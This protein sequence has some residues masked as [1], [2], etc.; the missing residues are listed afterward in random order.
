MIDSDA[1]NI[2]LEFGLFSQRIQAFVSKDIANNIR[3]L[4]VGNYNL[5]EPDITPPCTQATD[6]GGASLLLVLSPV[7]RLT[8]QSI[9]C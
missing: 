1:S 3:H 7:C 6:G 2:W 8:F 4:H 5:S 9:S